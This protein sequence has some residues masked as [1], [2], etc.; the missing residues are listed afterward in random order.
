MTG[1]TVTWSG[2][3]EWDAAASRARLISADIG[4]RTGAQLAQGFDPNYSPASVA[5][6]YWSF[7]ETSGALADVI[8]GRNATL[9]GGTRGQTGP[10][11]T[12][13]VRFDGVDDAATVSI[14]SDPVGSGSFS[15]VAWIDKE[16]VSD[17]DTLARHGGTAPGSWF[18]DHRS[19]NRIGFGFY[20]SGGTL[21]WDGFFH[22]GTS[23]LGRHVIIAVFN[24]GSGTLTVY[25]ND[26]AES[27][28]V[29]GSRPALNGD[30]IGF[31]Y[32]PYSG[33]VRYF[34]GAIGLVLLF[35]G[36]LTST[37]VNNVLDTFESGTL[38]SAGKSA[39][40]T[41]TTL[42]TT[43]TVPSD[44]TLD[45]EVRQATGS[46]TNTQSVA[47]GG[48][49]NTYPLA[50]FEDATDA[51]Y[52]IETAFAS[53]DT[54]RSAILLSASVETE[55]DDALE[56]VGYVPMAV[57]GT[58]HS[59]PVYAYEDLDVVGPRARAAN[60]A[61]GAFRLVDAAESKLRVRYGGTTYGV[62]LSGSGGG[63]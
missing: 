3:A 14:S 5:T 1:E 60:G 34:A 19:N 48:G 9:S 38:T 22:S 39:S 33:G 7:D 18:L 50:G 61:V 11:G 20:D 37:G 24:Q 36:A 27:I 2:Q 17:V 59:V 30:S 46:G 47:I 62:D 42:S 32:G 49:S 51:T 13:A 35:N 56:P 15:V 43:A 6:G 23:T 58:T 41:P 40:G 52:T 26:V 31:G 16:S 8:G 54:A 28:S 63:A 53:S 29:S 12:N 55:L 25:Q 10:L 44:T 57:D 4:V 45:V 21:R